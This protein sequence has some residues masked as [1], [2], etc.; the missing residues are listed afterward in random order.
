MY[1]HTAY[2]ELIVDAIET[3]LAWDVSDECLPDALVD[4]ARLLA[5]VSPDNPDDACLH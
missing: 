3:V 5:G 2:A 1:R 4:Q